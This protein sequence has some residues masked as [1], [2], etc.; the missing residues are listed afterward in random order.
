[1]SRRSKAYPFPIVC[2]LI[3]LAVFAAM[4]QPLRAG[5]QEIERLRQEIREKTAKQRALIVVPNEKATSAA[6]RSSVDFYDLQQGETPPDV[7]GRVS[8]VSE[9]IRQIGL[10]KSV[11]IIE[12]H[13]PESERISFG[14]QPYDV[15][16][17]PRLEVYKG[18]ILWFGMSKAHPGNI[19]LYYDP[20]DK[21]FDK[22]KWLRI[23]LDN[24]KRIS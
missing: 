1:M 8:S 15:L 17:W 12:S 21:N 7:A 23:F 11:E 9:A 4:A 6:A 10:Y 24:V 5:E 20:V 22:E 19:L 2:C 14:S 18:R 3:T 13:I 16:I